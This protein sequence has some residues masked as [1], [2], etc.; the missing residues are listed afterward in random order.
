MPTYSNATRRWVPLLIVGGLLALAAFAASVAAPGVHTIPL[1]IVSDSGSGSGNSGAPSNAPSF[2]SGG[3]VTPFAIPP[4]VGW[5]EAIFAG[6][7]VL[8]IVGLLIWHFLRNNWLSIREVERDSADDA[9]ALSVRREEVIAA[10]DEGI[11]QLATDRDPR[12][13]VIASWV[14]LEEVA[15]R[16]GTPRLASDAPADFV[17]RLLAAHQVSRSAL[18]SL[19]DLYRA[20]RYSTATIDSQMR[21]Q[22]IAALGRIR[23]ELLVSRPGTPVD[24]VLSGALPTGLPRPSVPSTPGDPPVRRWLT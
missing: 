10:L 14:R 16:A 17:A 22:A 1:P 3:P 19:A 6:A 7:V 11:A 24:D 8:L 2:P 18:T 23:H 12:A 5:I 15:H 9:D 13:A 20:A 4:W 21:D